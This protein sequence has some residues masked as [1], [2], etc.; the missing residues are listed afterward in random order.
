V[1]WHFPEDVLMTETAAKAV[2][3]AFCLKC[4]VQERDLGI[5]R[6]HAQETPLGLSA[7]QGICI[8]DVAA[9]SLRLT[10][11]LAEGFGDVLQTAVTIVR[12]ESHENGLARTIDLFLREFGNLA[13]SV[14]P[15]VSTPERPAEGDWVVV[16]APGSRAI[17]ES[18]DGSVE[19]EVVTYRY[20]PQGL[21]Y[22][23]VPPKPGA[24]WLVKASSVSPLHGDSTTIRVNLITGEEDV[25]QHSSSD[26]A[27]AA[28]FR[29]GLL[30]YVRDQLGE[31]PW[32]EIANAIADTVE[33]DT[34][35]AL[36][37]PDLVA[38][39]EGR[40]FAWRDVHVVVERLAQ[41]PSALLERVFLSVK[42]DPPSK[43]EPEEVA[44]R[45]RAS[46]QK[47]G[48]GRSGWLMWA[49]G[50]KVVWRR[51]GGQTVRATR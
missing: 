43:I 7:R 27:D 48:S 11:R 5:G 40:G 42:T 39:A 14:T 3:T 34:G 15:E 1:C 36:T 20:T 25:G 49:K 21:L 51:P 32:V 23:L 10:Q 44:R 41:S 45:L 47:D 35:Q 4:G 38:F 12:S 28:E 22:E 18:E 13:R 30:G 17:Y 33:T 46:M 16:V 2:L 50:V 19:V 31:S 26:E 9:G 6:F 29:K 24:K 8:Y 37:L